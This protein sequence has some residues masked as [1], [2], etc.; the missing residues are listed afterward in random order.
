VQ[1]ALAAARRDGRPLALLLMDLDRFKHANDTF[2]HHQGDIV[3]KEIGLRLQ[4]NLRE[5]DTIARL[6]GDEFGVLLPLTGRRRGRRH[7]QSARGRG[8]AATD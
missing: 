1:Q 4:T 3:L 5:S 7:T 6:G 2:G 8:A